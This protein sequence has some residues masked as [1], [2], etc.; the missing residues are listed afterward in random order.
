MNVLGNVRRRWIPA[1]ML[2]LLSLSS[3][4][5]ADRI[6]MPAT[7]SKTYAQEC[8]SCHMAYP[9][10]LLPPD[11]WRR[12]VNSLDKHYGT[13]ASLDAQSARAI[14]DWL[15]A[16]AGTYKRAKEAPPDNRIT[17]SA[18]FTRK[19]RELPAEVWRRASVRTAANCNACHL[20]AEQGRFN[21]DDVRIP[22]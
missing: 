5:F 1:T 15:G 9:P 6:R 14:G 2:A 21:D 16:N 10:G 7:S 19:H 4:A 18:W 8:A 17:R 11:S 22:R 20:G 3:A 13:D 12:I